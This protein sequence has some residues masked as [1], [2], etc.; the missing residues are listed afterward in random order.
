MLVSLW[1]T[2][3]GGEVFMCFGEVVTFRGDSNNWQTKSG[4]ATSFCGC[5]DRVRSVY[6]SLAAAAGAAEHVAAARL[7][8]KN[9]KCAADYWPATGQQVDATTIAAIVTCWRLLS[10]ASD[11]PSGAAALAVASLCMP[12]R[13]I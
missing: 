13:S 6:F 7:E 12:P 4:R 1:P 11:R 3:A 8:K 9:K 2:F 5:G 10:A